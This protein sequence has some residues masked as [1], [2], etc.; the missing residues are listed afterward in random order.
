[1]QIRL[2]LKNILAGLHGGVL[3][4]PQSS[5]KIS[6]FITLFCFFKH[7]VDYLCYQNG[8]SCDIRL[9]NTDAQ[10]PAKETVL[11]CSLCHEHFTFY[12]LKLSQILLIKVRLIKERN[13]LQWIKHVTT[14][15][16]FNLS[17]LF[18]LK[19][20]LSHM[21]ILH[22]DATSALKQTTYFTHAAFVVV[23]CLLKWSFQLQSTNSHP[24]YYR[25]K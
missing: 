17:L 7:G 2:K 16:L 8:L 12:H 13:L 21:K 11:L 19:R 5:A 20:M 22:L 18:P 23:H 6:F 3:N 4:V 10:A 15:P 25:P 9:I 14:F 24:S 1:M